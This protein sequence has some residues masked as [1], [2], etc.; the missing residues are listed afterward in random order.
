M[1]KFI[2]SKA[3]Y[4]FKPTDK[5]IVAGLQNPSNFAFAEVAGIE[6]IAA[7]IGSGKAWR[8]G[9][10][11]KGITSFRKA[12][13]KAAQII[14]LDF[15][16]C[17]SK[18][19]EI[20]DYAESLGICPSAWYYSYS[21]GKKSG[22]NFRVLWVLAEPIK[23]IQYETICKNLLEQ[24]AAFNPDK[25][26]KDV[27]RLWFG[28]ASGVNVISRKPIPLSVIG[29]L[30]VCEKLKNGQ[31]TDK[32]K[33]AVKACEK[34]YYS[35]AAAEDLEPLYISASLPWYD[36]LQR[37]CWLW[38]KWV[39][40]EYLNYNQRLTLFTNL[41][42]L[43]Y[44]DAN[45]SI[46][47][48][49]LE[50]YNANK[51]VYEGHTCDEAQIRSMF[52]N[53]TLYARGIVKTDGDERITVKD[54][55]AS[56]NASS[57]NDEPKITLEE[58]D[59]QLNQRFPLILSDDRIVYIDAQTAC[60]KTERVIQ[61]L[62]RQDLTQ[63]TIIYSVPQYINIS[64]FEER[65]RAAYREANKG[66]PF[67]DDIDIINIIPRGNYKRKD[68][69]LMGLGF[70]PS[71]RQDERYHAIQDM[72]NPDKK[73]LFVC[74]HQCLVHLR[75]INADCII[76]DENIE[77]A[78]IFETRFDS[79]GLN[80]LTSCMKDEYKQPVR[81]FIDGLDAMEQG[82]EVDITILRE[83]MAAGFDWDR[84]INSRKIMEGV[85]KILYSYGAKPVISKE[86]GKSVIR[87][88]SKSN[89][90]DEAIQKHIPIKFL[91]ATPQSTK[92]K[93]LYD[94]DLI[95]NEHFDRAINYG[96][97]IQ[98]SGLT[99]AKGTKETQEDNAIKL[100]K[101]V[102]EKIPEDECRQAYVLTYKDTM[103]IWER[104][105]F[106]IPMYNGNKVHI[107]NS[108]G[109]DFLKG[110]IVIVAGKPDLPEFKYN[111]LYHDLYPDRA[112]E[113]TKGYH[114]LVIG[115]RK[116]KVYLF[117]DEKLRQIQIENI[118]LFLEQSVGRARA[119]REVGA[120]VYVFTDFI[121]S[122]VNTFYF[123]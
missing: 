103:E 17:P 74:S 68:Y 104:N 23:P 30:G 55:I 3:G 27:S 37:K 20:I 15:D 110:K 11:D 121:L 46:V 79:V 96:V 116:K 49:V 69:I 86:N 29:W 9:L 63:K 102:K 98:Y 33:K 88:K 89:L 81:A 101:Y 71:T 10:Y 35:E 92:L 58:L 78:C 97:I 113:P 40:G 26:T 4:D 47:S 56:G 76:V 13:V 38:D 50:Y 57:D 12:N 59:A 6:D 34:D 91:S 21:Q 41:K 60:G 119:L 16:N 62:L 70:T 120:R 48:K 54:Y 7:T 2:Y 109:M 112:D 82:Q 24:F 8:A 42:Y 75:G 117:N 61:W 87:F 18:P 77:D 122:D 83:A 32:A 93:A 14:A 31:T 5:G 123:E 106:K 52:L 84:Y 65:Y 94:T 73:G 105:G 108:A 80:G 85:A 53:T 64:E 111:D 1:I 95:E 114:D 39:S 100:I 22:Y 99:A 115:T 67:N 36:M 90:I 19:Q 43:R 66:K 25:S 51:S 118:K 44:N 45:M 28:T 107:A 72:I